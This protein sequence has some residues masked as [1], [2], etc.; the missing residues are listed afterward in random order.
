MA[1]SINSM[2]F[3]LGCRNIMSVTVYGEANRRSIVIVSGLDHPFRGLFSLYVESLNRE[4]MV[5]PSVRKGQ[6]IIGYEWNFESE[7]TRDYQTQ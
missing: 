6:R 7:R 3:L 1:I 4:S 2:Q 5:V